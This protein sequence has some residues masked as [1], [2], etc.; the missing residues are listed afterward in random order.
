MVPEHI[1]RLN[2]RDGYFDAFYEELAS[3]TGLT[4]KAAY[5]NIE[6][7]YEA[8]YG[9]NRYSTYS[10]FRNAKRRYLDFLASKARKKA[11]ST[12]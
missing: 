6:D 3:H 10:S 8:W 4:H 12:V 2:S 5:L 9:V 1:K 7:R 11:N